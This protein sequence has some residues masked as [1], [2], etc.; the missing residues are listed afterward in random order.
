MN[1]NELAAQR[2]VKLNSLV[3]VD[4]HRSLYTGRVTMISLRG[5]NVT[6]PECDKTSFVKWYNVREIIEE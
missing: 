2:K 5:I 6:L 4:I 1:F 3:R